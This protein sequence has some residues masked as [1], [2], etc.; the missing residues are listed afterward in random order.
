MIITIGNTKGGVGKTTIACNLAVCAAIDG[1]KVL[2]IDADTQGSSMAFRA[3]RESTD[4]KAMSITTPTL[5][6][7]LNGFDNIDLIIIDAGGRDSA[8]FR[9]AMLASDLLVIPS[10]PSQV[11]FWAVNDVLEL[12]KEARVYKEIKACF[13]L[14]QMQPNTTL[15]K[16]AKEAID[17][18]DA[19]VRP[20]K[21]I[22]NARIAYKK[23]FG[24]GKS[25]LEWSDPKAREE[26]TSLYNEILSL[27]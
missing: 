2:L 8:V 25:V 11:D 14:N 15:S 18:F 5:H 22:I 20:L 16:E 13:L 7:D 23:S 4:I 17:E 3:S 27:R 1:K 10:M 9:S 21:T 26:I 24:E 12:L 6:K 19:D